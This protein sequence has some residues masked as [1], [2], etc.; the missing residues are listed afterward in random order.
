LRK[1]IDEPEKISEPGMQPFELENGKLAYYEE[2][3]TSQS[4]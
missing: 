4:I 1:V 3:E 2:G